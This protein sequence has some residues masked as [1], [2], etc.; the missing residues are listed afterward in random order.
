M[1]IN[2]KNISTEDLK[3]SMEIQTNELVISEDKLKE[4]ISTLTTNQKAVKTQIEKLNS[5]SSLELFTDPKKLSTIQTSVKQS[6]DQV[7]QMMRSANIEIAEQEIVDSL[8]DGLDD[9]STDLINFQESLTGQTR[10][11][12]MLEVIFETYLS[13]NISQS[14]ILREDILQIALIDVLIHLD[15]YPDLDKK[16]ISDITKLIEIS[17]SCNHSSN[18]N[19]SEAQRKALVSNVWNKLASSLPA[20][21]LA[22]KAFTKLSGSSS[23]SATIPSTLL[24]QYTD[25]VYFEGLKGGWVSRYNETLS[26]MLKIDLVITLIA[27]TEIT[28]DQINS[29]LTHD[30]D[31]LDTLDEI[32]KSLTGQDSIR[33]LMGSKPGGWVNIEHEFVDVFVWGEFNFQGGLNPDYI[34]ELSKGLETGI[35]PEE[36]KEINRLG[37]NAKMIMNTLQTWLSTIANTIKT[38]LNNL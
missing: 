33:Y 11:T 17:G 20:D 27:N 8:F 2:I 6:T 21:S 31:T 38:M 15:D 34:L 7:N 28:E 9:I 29:I 5:Y 32:V 19:M 36:I 25:S 13:Q 3:H 16:L 12:K 1:L 30:M 10:L 23:P 14:P 26:P 35:T 22:Y 18:D 37:D 4:L 24:N